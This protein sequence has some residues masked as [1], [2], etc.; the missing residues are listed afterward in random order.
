MFYFWLLLILAVGI[1]WLFFYKKIYIQTSTMAAVMAF[2][3]FTEGVL[4]N[5][6]GVRFFHSSF[7]KILSICNL[8]IWIAFIESF[9]IAF[10]NGRFKK[11]HYTNQINRFGIGTWVA[12]TSICGIILYKQF[13]EWRTISEVITFLNIL[14]WVT[15]IGISLKTFIEIYRTKLYGKVHGIILLTTVSTQSIVLLMTTVF[16]NFPISA[17]LSFL[18]IGFGFY[19]LSVF[20]IFYRYGTTSWSIEADWNNTNCIVH[21]ALSISGIA[22]MMSAV[23]PFEIIRTIWWLSAAMFLAVESIEVYR[24]VRRIQLLGVK[25]GLFI[26]DVTQWSRIFTFAMFYTF[27]SFFHPHFSIIQQVKHAVLSI[28]VWIIILLLS[29]EIILCADYMLKLIKKSSQKIGSNQNIG[30]V[31][32]TM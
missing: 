9:F 23:V 16:K 7:G 19:L 21:G 32:G 6:F 24:L 10:I 13:V 18:F 28:G 1:G 29:V 31:S 4:L 5:H 27:T 14:L 15:Y 25:K 20:I 11:L 30:K 12:G 3:I 17:T 22:C 8:S 26:Y 2:G